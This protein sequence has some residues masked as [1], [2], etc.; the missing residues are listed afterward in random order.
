MRQ[1]HRIKQENSGALLL[2]R[3]GDFYELF[4]DDAI[5]A[6]KILGIALTSRN[7]GESSKTPLCGFPYHAL[8]R[9]CAK[10]IA[11][12][13]KVAVCE[14]TSDP[15]ESKGIVDRDVIEVISRGTA[16]NPEVLHDKTNNYIM[17]V[18]ETG[19]T[20]GF[21]G[22][23]VSTGEFFCG[24]A[25]LNT[26][27]RE[28]EKL[29]AV[30]ILYPASDR[31]SVPMPFLTRLSNSPLLTPAPDW[32]FSRE[33]AEKT[34][35]NHFGTATLEGFGVSNCNAGLMAANALFEFIREQKKGRT[36]HI[37]NIV[38]LK[39]D[40]FMALDGATIKNLEILNPIN[41]EDST[42]TLLH[43]IDC[44]K[45]AMGGRIIKK[46]LINPLMQVS[47]IEKRQ[48]L[49][50]LFFNNSD[51]REKT[52]TLLAGI[53]DIERLS[54]RIGYER[55][56]PRDIANL[57]NSLLTIE[58][59]SMILQTEEKIPLLQ[60]ILIKI[61][62]TEPITEHISRAVVD[63]PPMSL[64]DGGVFKRGYS[65]LL[66]SIVDGAVEGK[67]WIASFQP[68]ER[69]RTGISS[70]KVG[71]T[72]VFGYYIEVTKSNIDK[73]PQ[74]YI[75]KQTI[76]NGERYITE[77]L[78]IWEEK[79]L[80][81]EEKQVECETALFDELRKWLLNHLG[82]IQSVSEGIAMLDALISFAETAAKNDFI[83]PMLTEDDSIEIEDGRHPVVETLLN[84]DTFVPNNTSIKNGEDFIHLIT[85]PNMA[86]K[87]TYLRQIGLIALLAQVGSYVPAK[88][89]KIGVVDRIFTRVGASDRLAKGL[90]TFLVE[91]QELANILN[92]ATSKSLVLLDE[93]GRGTSTFDGLSIAWSLVEHIHDHIG[94][95][96]LFATHY[97][98]LADLPLVMQGVKNY[99]VSVREWKDEIV[100]LRKILEGACDHSYGIQ[101][102]RL[103]GVPQTV[104][105]R[106]KEVLR[107]LESNELTP[108]Q[109]P[110]LAKKP[111]TKTGRSETS[112]SGPQLSLFSA[113]TEDII[114]YIKKIDINN[115]T[116]LQAL[117]ILSDIKGKL[118]A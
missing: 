66:D 30:E 67:E 15:K 102:A 39:T 103:A 26:A 60:E 25:D 36:D 107:N 96:T 88:K 72:K 27:I 59:T 21:S 58:Q 76:V 87:S 48:E 84:G 28:I 91:M 64:S 62:G 56:T 23:D 46:L 112:H 118:S 50:S 9:Y 92:N 114:D 93:I 108:D 78:K 82:K 7:H 97:H 101:V 104:I 75:R 44:T 106:A 6:S 94:A 11:A 43:I 49:V 89:A 90:S 110:S 37:R 12:G 35:A 61:S 51:L 5:T 55:A 116:P 32:R 63:A 105:D 99:N 69:E 20:I 8:D 10:L 24:E 115:C 13:N 1:Y 70:L 65:A 79:V 113:P 40:C 38:P 74:D 86:G 52:R 47:E 73:V 109:K 4:D 95:K 29:S 68:R 117:S 19:K 80:S 83:K 33:A 98:E 31:R 57:R 100:F 18:I 81:A 42:G 16:T 71:F 34:L 54:G 45:T 77:E 111:S 2:F 22:A 85:G 3:M 14:Q 17:A 41:M 53:S